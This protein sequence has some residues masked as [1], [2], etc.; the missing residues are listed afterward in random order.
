[1]QRPVL[2]CTIAILLVAAPV[3]SAQHGHV[4]AQPKPSTHIQAVK[5]APAPHGQTAPKAHV[6]GGSAKPHAPTPHVSGKAGAHAAGNAKTT[7]KTATTTKTK[8][9]AA[10]KK[11]TA[12]TTKTAKTTAKKTTTTGTTPTTPTG[13]TLTPVQQKLLK[14]TNLA[15]KLN[16]RL[17]AGTDLMAASAGFRNLGQFVA[18]VNVSNNLNI[19]FLELKARMVDQGMSLGQAIHDARPQ[20]DSQFVVR[21]AEANADTM[22]RSTEPPSTTTVKT[23][24][25]AKPRKTNGN[26]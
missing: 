10:G 14:N 7:V 5:P 20:V 1:M 11:T 24:A 9:S 6:S 12:K 25:K 2:L 19:P 23:K 4:G 15:Q 18:A 26:G 13:V 8:S 21:R 22:I 3:L 17:P 16:G